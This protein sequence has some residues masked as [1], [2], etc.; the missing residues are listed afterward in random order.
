VKERERKSARIL[1]RQ[2]YNA[3]AAV[4]AAAIMLHRPTH[5]KR[6]IKE[7]RARATQTPTHKSKS[8]G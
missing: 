8:N 7:Y 1:A 6:A 4:A 2:M 3:V 5:L